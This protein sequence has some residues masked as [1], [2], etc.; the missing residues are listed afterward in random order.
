MMRPHNINLLLVIILCA[1]IVQGCKLGGENRNEAGNQGSG[2][3]ATE[4]KQETGKKTRRLDGYTLRG[5]TFSY[6]LVPSGLSRDELL[7]TAG[8]IHR[9]EPDAQLI[10]V[11]DESGVQDYITYVKAVSQGDAEAKLPKEWADKHIVANL[12][13]LMSGKWMLYEGY[14]Y[15]EIGEVK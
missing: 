9:D 12:Q 11:D 8:E 6:Y 2:N 7:K 15:K 13:K 5:L 1:G 14:G 3:S 4:S 10:L